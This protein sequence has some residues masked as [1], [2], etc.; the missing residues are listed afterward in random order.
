MA[1]DLTKQIVDAMKE[2]S[3]STDEEIQG[4]LNDVA[5][6][7]K[8]RLNESSPTRTGKYAKS[9]KVKLEVFRDGCKVHIHNTRYQLTHLLEKGHKVR[10]GGRASAYP[11]IEKV[12][13]WAK[14]EAENRIKRI[15]WR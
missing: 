15:F 4:I 8:Q 13:A 1:D 7:A 10:N 14:K 9:W 11:H 12:D 5:K 6:E 3:K 2:F